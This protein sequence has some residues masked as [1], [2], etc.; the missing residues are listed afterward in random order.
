MFLS[1]PWCRHTFVILPLPPHSPYAPCGT[2]LCGRSICSD[3]TNCCP[4][5]GPCKICVGDQCVPRPNPFAAAACLP[6][7]GCTFRGARA[8]GS[9]TPCGVE[10]CAPA[11]MCNVI[12]CAT[13]RCEVAYD[14]GGNPFPN[15][16][17]VTKTCQGCA[18]RSCTWDDEGVV[19]CVPVPACAT[20]VCPAG[21]SCYDGADGTEAARCFPRDVAACGGCLDDPGAVCELVRGAQAEDSALACVKRHPAGARCEKDGCACAGAPCQGLEQC[22]QSGFATSSEVS[23]K[24]VTVGCAVVS[25]AAADTRDVDPCGSVLCGAGRECVHH[26]ARAAASCRPV[27]VERCRGTVCT[28]P[29]LC[30]ERTGVCENANCV[31]ACPLDEQ[32]MFVSGAS[33]CVRNKCPTEDEWWLAGTCLTDTDCDDDVFSVC[34]APTS[35][36]LEAYVSAHCTCNPVTGKAGMTMTGSPPPLPSR[37]TPS[38]A[39]RKM[40][41]ARCVREPHPTRRRCIRA[42]WNCNVADSKSWSPAEL[43]WCCQNR[44]IGCCLNDERK[45]G[46]ANDYQCTTP[47]DP[48]TWSADKIH[49]CC[50]KTQLRGCP[51]QATPPLPA[52][53][54]RAASV[55]LLLTEYDCTT[56]EEFTYAKKVHCCGQ[57]KIAC[58][59]P[60]QDCSS[61]TLT[62]EEKV[63]CCTSEGKV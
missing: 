32:C 50:Q 26:P 24:L 19:A 17:P 53:R 40:H 46:C 55:L 9:P 41:T 45:K 51:I 47:D 18:S 58:P 6:V 63:R 56:E 62:A 52:P 4:P 61:T 38:R 1:L 42:R 10:E 31:P 44:Q 57:K 15:C 28:P 12:R 2:L 3:G 27:P 39:P 21:M 54:S 35:T 30:N 22:V 25:D 43:L 11:Q 14:A 20:T 33:A 48:T 7:A 8:A 5:S 36:L 60:A 37:P 49:G 59:V 13:G 23:T 29:A 34:P 16:L